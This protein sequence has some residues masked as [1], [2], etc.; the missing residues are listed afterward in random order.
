[1][2][3]TYTWIVNQLECYPEKDG[4]Q[5]VVFS[6]NWVCYGYEMANQNQYE[7]CIGGNANVTLNPDEPYIPYDQLTEEQVLNWIWTSGVDK[8]LTEAEVYAKIQALVNPTVVS[9]PLP[10]LST[11]T[12]V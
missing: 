2:A 8:D 1:M 11:P 5:D 6:I 12:P 3:T 10:W 9:P 4:Y 7:S